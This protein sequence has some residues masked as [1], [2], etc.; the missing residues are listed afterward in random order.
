MKKLKAFIIFMI[1]LF[2]ASTTWA[3]ESSV[4]DTD[5]IDTVRRPDSAIQIQAVAI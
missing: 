5:I 4:P 2:F 3:A 1:V